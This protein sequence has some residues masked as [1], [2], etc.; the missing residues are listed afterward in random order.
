MTFPSEAAV[1]FEDEGM[2]VGFGVVLPITG[3]DALDGGGKCDKKPPPSAVVVPVKA[4]I[5]Q[6][7]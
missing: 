3:P 6:H 1:A 4:A 5:V 7:C 2:D